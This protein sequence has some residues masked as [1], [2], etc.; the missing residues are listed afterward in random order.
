MPLLDPIDD[1]KIKD[2]AFKEIVTKNDL[3]EKRLRSHPMHKNPD[4]K[5]LLDSYGRKDQAAKELEKAKGEVKRA[6]SL[7]QMNDLKCMKRVLRRMGYSTMADVIEVKGR[8]ACELSS[9]DELLLTEMMFNG[10]F[11]EMSPEQCASIL[12]CFVCDEKS[13]EAPRHSAPFLN[14]A[15]L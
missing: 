10:M 2:K 12:S 1:L 14:L 4:R 3:Y 6:K 8:I 9:A 11:N 13:N 15:P 7:L 5:R